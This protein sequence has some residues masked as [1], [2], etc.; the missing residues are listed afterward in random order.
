M[1]YLVTGARGFVMSVLVKELLTA[2]PDATVTA[3]D[4]HAPD[5]VLTSY[6]GADEGRVR[7]VRADV[8]DAGAM[9]DTIRARTPDV[10]IHGATVTHDASTERRDPERFIRVNVGG[11]T[12]VLDAARRTDGVR[13]VLL[14]SSGAVYGCSPEQSLTEETPPAP[15]EMYGISKVAG[16]LIA[17]RFSRLYGLHVPV[18]RLTKMFGP[19]ERPS[20]G[21]AV[22][23]LPYHLAA[24]AVR[25]RPL[26]ITDRTPRAGGDWL[27]VT[28]AAQ[29]LRLLAVTEGEGTRTYNVSRGIRTAVPELADLFGVEMLQVPAGTADA[30]MDPGT[31]FGKN[32]IYA[33][34]RAQRELAWKPTDLKDQVAEYVAWAHRHPDFFPADR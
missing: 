6:L 25:N 29:A 3:V 30:D 5:D 24:A 8:T 16:E 13:R 19:M 7:F 9:A 17:R 32:G 18:A 10:I 4:L 33:S 21:R 14:I 20:S 2:E 26:R 23:S 1:H 27:S 11:T 31:E 34:D 28:Q 12:N 22:M 15:D